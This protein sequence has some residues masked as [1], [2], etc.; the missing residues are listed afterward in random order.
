MDEEAP[1]F[2]GEMALDVRLSPDGGGRLIKVSVRSQDD[3]A[4]VAPEADAI[5]PRP[6]ARDAIP[7]FVAG[8]DAGLFR[9]PAEDQ[10]AE[11]LNVTA[12]TR[13]GERIDEWEI[14]TPPLEVDAFAALARMFWAAGA[15]AVA[16]TQNAPAAR[17]TVRSFEGA[18][19]HTPRVVRWE[20]ESTL[21]DSAKNAV[22]LVCFEH[23][24]APEIVQS[25]H[26]ALRAWAAVV[27]HGG[28]TGGESYPISAALLSELGTELA[29]E[30]FAT[31]DALVVG[32]DGWA[33]LREGLSRAHRKEPIKRVEMR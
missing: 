6:R 33:A 28:F 25:V 24:A 22:V 3:S 29:S 23:D 17:L 5:E 15:R 13:D 31:F 14:M 27:E 16:M 26:A 12:R 18:A 10:R 1:K 20:V 30:V 21:E 19:P 8:V 4:A 2:P 9:G 11:V 7:V 32:P